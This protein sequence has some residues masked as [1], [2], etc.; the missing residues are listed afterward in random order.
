MKR[1]QDA[2][3]PYGFK[4]ILT[5]KLLDVSA[6]ADQF[7]A[8]AE[9][10]ED[11]KERAAGPQLCHAPGERPIIPGYFPNISHSAKVLIAGG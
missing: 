6:R 1:I 2:C 7:K 9:F 3:E 4:R 5:Q 8:I 11:W 10:C